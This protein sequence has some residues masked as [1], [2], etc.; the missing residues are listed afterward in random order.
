LPAGVFLSGSRRMALQSH[1]LFPV[2]EPD[3]VDKHV[4]DED[5]EDDGE[6]EIDNV[7]A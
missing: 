2:F 5:R 3:V 4:R 6:Q 7:N 1:P